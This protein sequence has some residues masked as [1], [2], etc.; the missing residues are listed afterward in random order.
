MDFIRNKAKE[1]LIL[2]VEEHTEE[3]WKILCKIFGLKE[4]ERIV[5]KDYTLEAWGIK[6]AQSVI[7]EED[8]EKA[9]KHLEF[10]IVEYA[11]IGFS[12]QL[13]LQATLI[14]LRKRYENGERTLQLY[15]AM[16]EIE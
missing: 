2:E 9:I 5:V 14:P 1:P 11:S 4:A 7:S 16:M 10:Y 6:N 8:W 3:E 12:G 13:A 15:E